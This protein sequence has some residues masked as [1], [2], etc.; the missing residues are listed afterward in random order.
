[1]VL[2]LYYVTYTVTYTIIPIQIYK[3]LNIG[4]VCNII[5]YIQTFSCNP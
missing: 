2:L 3:S 5:V 1:M 4:H